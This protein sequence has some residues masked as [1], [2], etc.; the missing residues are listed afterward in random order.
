MKVFKRILFLMIAFSLILGSFAGVVSANTED[1]KQVEEL[2]KQ[3]EFLFEEAAIKDR[4]GNIINFD[5]EKLEKNF[6]PIPEIKELESALKSGNTLQPNKKIIAMPVVKNDVII[7]PNHHIPEPDAFDACLYRKITTNFKEVFS[8]NAIGTVI[9][10][11]HAKQY[12]KAATQ[13]LKMG[14]RGN[15]ISLTGQIA[16]YWGQCAIEVSKK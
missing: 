12:T 4:D 16:W 6:G 11:I 9:T 14:V 13:L 2:A 5:I 1:S 15:I 10:L 8:V 7:T 3:L